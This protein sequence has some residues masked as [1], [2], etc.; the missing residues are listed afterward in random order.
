MT[1]HQSI[2]IAVP[3][4]T[5][6]FTTHYAMQLRLP[7]AKEDK[8]RKKRPPIVSTADSAPCGMCAPDI[9]LRN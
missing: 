9:L 3:P 4:S 7:R 2:W 5:C 6:S 8:P 1:G